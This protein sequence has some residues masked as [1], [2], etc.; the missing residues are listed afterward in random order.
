MGPSPSPETGLGPKDAARL[1]DTA[2]TAILEGL[3]GRSH[4]IIAL[5]ELPDALGRTLGSFV[6]LHVDDELNGCIGN[7]EGIEPL[8]HAVPR[9]AWS[10]A[11]ADPRLPAL[12]PSERDRLR[13]EISLLSPLSPLAAD[14]YSALI[15][16]VRPGVDGV[17]VQMGRRQGLF[18]P[19]V[20]TQLPEADTF[21]EQL[22]RKAGLIARSWTSETRV[23]RFTTTTYRRDPGPRRP[24]RRR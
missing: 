23:H 3:A 13:I 10:A 20:W 18:L 22:F 7:V 15:A 24:T 6:T 21:V 4:Q 14:S 19:S 17:V 8:G 11:F 16:N 1:L 5:Q 12:E 2:D 9:L